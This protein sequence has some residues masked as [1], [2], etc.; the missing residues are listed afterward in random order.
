M[1]FLPID[2]RCIVGAINRWC[3]VFMLS[4]EYNQY[5]LRFLLFCTRPTV[6]T[7][8]SGT[9]Y[10]R[11]I[12]TS[13]LSEPAPIIHSSSS[14][15]AIQRCA[16]L[17]FFRSVRCCCLMCTWYFFLLAH[18][19]SKLRAHHALT[20]WSATWGPACGDGLQ[21]CFIVGLLRSRY[22]TSFKVYVYKKQKSDASKNSSYTLLPQCVIC[23]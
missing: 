1:V 18:R 21:N 11:H 12:A 22:C 10:L 20:T 16:V 23:A 8:I 17:L 15:S 9:Y 19:I 14:A 4:Y 5:K 13:T 2:C 3:C 6:H 7:S